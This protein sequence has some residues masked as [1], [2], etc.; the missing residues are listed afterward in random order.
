ML[1]RYER[2]VHLQQ[3]ELKAFREKAEA[4]ASH[5]EFEIA[6]NLETI[7]I[8]RL[9]LEKSRPMPQNPLLSALPRQPRAGRMPSQES[10]RDG[11]GTH[12]S[13]SD[14]IRSAAASILREERRP[15]K[16]AELKQQMD[17]RGIEIRSGDPVDLIRA[18][19]RRA[20]EFKHIPRVGYILSET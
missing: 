5:L 8:L 1:S 18:A 14:L 3:E 11:G 7:E 20:P 16:Q 2:S 10:E 15:L 13:Q 19:L 12:Q 4:Y 17:A 9:Q 6:G